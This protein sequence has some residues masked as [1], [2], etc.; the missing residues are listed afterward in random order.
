MMGALGDGR[1]DLSGFDEVTRRML[2]A[3]AAKGHPECLWRKAQW[4]YPGVG[5]DKASLESSLSMAAR[6]ASAGAYRAAAHLATHFRALSRMDLR[7]V[8]RAYCW[9]VIHDQSASTASGAALVYQTYLVT[10]RADGNPALES[11]LLALKVGSHDTESCI[12]LGWH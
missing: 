1:Q 2:D 10:A 4:T 6:A 3:G 12:A 8:E 9:S 5:G 7:Y 11:R